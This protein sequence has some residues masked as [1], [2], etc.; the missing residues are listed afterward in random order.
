M[1][2]ADF[3]TNFILYKY[4]RISEQFIIPDRPLWFIEW[5]MR[6]VVHKSTYIIFIYVP[7]FQYTLFAFYT[8]YTSKWDRGFKRYLLFI[9]RFPAFILKNDFTYP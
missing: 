4:T 2:V 3:I 8:L 6:P 5:D 7:N 9:S 1:K